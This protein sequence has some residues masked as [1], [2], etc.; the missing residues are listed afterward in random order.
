MA[1]ESIGT[2]I[3]TA[4]PGYTDSADI[5]AALRAYHYGSYSYDPANTS[6]ASLI[7]PSIAKTIYDL[8]ETTS[9]FV[10]LDG[11]QTLTNK[12][13][14]SPTVSGLYL[15]DSSITIEGA[16]TNTHQTTLTVVDPTQDNTITFP[17]TSGNLVID[18]FSQTLT[19]KTIS[20]A[21]NTLTVRL[22]NDVSGTLP[23]ANGGTG[24]TSFG[25]G[26][27]TFLG[28]PSSANLATAVTDETGSGALVFATSP[29]LVTPV[30][31]V[32]TGTSFNSITGLSSTNP[33]ALGA[34]APGIGTT[35]ARADHVHPTTGLGLT[36]S[37]LNQFA[38]TTSSQLAGVISDETGSGAL[39][40]GTSP[41]LTAPIINL[42]TNTQTGT[43][44]T[45]I[46]SDNGKL[47]TLDNASS[48]TLTVPTNISVSYATGAQINLL[49]LGLG[50]V[51][52]VGD[53]GVTVY[54]TPGA[55]FR[56][57]YSAATLI[58]LDTDTWLLT[59][60]LSA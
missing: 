42:A 45:P 6:P 24:I 53:T 1:T 17:N 34:A 8:Q 47:V 55:N 30:L 20:G 9:S 18:N 36:A 37:G 26:I 43:T 44:Y 19:N 29:T 15:S 12:T 58:K 31:G 49:Q 40:F 51:T 2:L 50:Q 5:Q 33:A 52:V 4:I 11:V 38:S 32:A 13:L 22:A 39:V 35:T 60:D 56:A 59:G 48:I 25:T 46:L 28:T 54:S 3:P 16:S 21:N 57:Q 7:T 10:T 41:T 23:V 27:A 14:T